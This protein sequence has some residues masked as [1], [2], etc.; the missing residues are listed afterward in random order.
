MRTSLFL[1]AAF[2]VPVL[3]DT[4]SQF[5]YFFPEWSK[6]LTYIRDN[7]CSDDYAAY[8]D[9]DKPRIH[10]DPSGYT[11]INFNGYYLANCILDNMDEFQK[12]EMG[13]V[14]VVLGLLPTLLTMIGPTR[15]EV[16]LLAL[17]RPVLAG[18]LSLSQPVLRQ[19]DAKSS[20]WENLDVPH[21]LR[22]LPFL[23]RPDS[24]WEIMLLAIEYVT[25]MGAVANLVYLG[26]QL[27]YKSITVSTIAFNTLPSTYGTLLWLI[28]MVAINLLSTL[29][30]WL[31]CRMGREEPPSGTPHSWLS[32]QLAPRITV[33]NP[34]ALM[35]VHDVETTPRFSATIYAL[36]KLMSF[37]ADMGV[38]ALFIYA[39]IIM[40]S[41]LF[42]SMWDAV[43][44]MAQI[45]AGAMASKLVLRFELHG[46]H[47]RQ[48]GASRP[49]HVET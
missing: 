24:W 13:V 47:A 5:Q 38:V 7:N 46:M 22:I 1:L 20:P 3:C 34:K 2:V 10:H 28:L 6:E 23:S 26:V 19:A 30:L 33:H 29:D 45:L 32:I 21:V 37:L 35:T 49:P 14:A 17:R 39:T 16:S 25:A 15:D 48:T 8:I 18:L 31:R 12:A 36:Q 27:A 11:P 40:S 43:K 41:Q 42:I 44:L 4:F 9:P